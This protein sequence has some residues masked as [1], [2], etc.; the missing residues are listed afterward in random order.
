M[1][2]GE[3]FKKELR[4]R[5]RFGKCLPKVRT[6]RAGRHGTGNFVLRRGAKVL[7]IG[8]REAVKK[9]LLRNGKSNFSKKGGGIT[10]TEN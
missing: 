8:H 2:D 3:L 1:R 7:E 10:P 9:D 5:Q 6:R 4:A